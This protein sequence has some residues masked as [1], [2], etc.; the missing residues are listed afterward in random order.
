[1][2]ETPINSTNN[3]KSNDRRFCGKK[4]LGTTETL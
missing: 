4:D 2:S 3:D 1:M